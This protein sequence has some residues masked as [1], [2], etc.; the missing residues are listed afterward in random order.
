M[1][2]LAPAVIPTLFLAGWMAGL[3]VW[4]VPAVI[5]WRIIGF[6]VV[7][8]AA[9]MAGQAAPLISSDLGEWGLGTGILAAL[10][11]P[12]GMSITVLVLFSYQSGDLGPGWERSWSVIPA[13]AVQVAALLVVGAGLALQRRDRQPA[14]HR[15]G[16]WLVITGTL[17][18][19]TAVASHLCA[20]AYDLG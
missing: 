16:R 6:V 18:G 5:D 10:L 19:A 15:L 2:R 13:L 11:A 20:V 3:A 17:A 8:S 1:R 7:L 12:L 4:P 14:S 9:V